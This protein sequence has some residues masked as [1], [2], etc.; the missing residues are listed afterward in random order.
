[1]SVEWYSSTTLLALRLGGMV[2]QGIDDRCGMMYACRMVEPS[3]V[4][5]ASTAGLARLMRLSLLKMES[6]KTAEAT[7]VAWALACAESLLDWMCFS[8]AI[9]R[10]G[11]AFGFLVDVSWCIVTPFIPL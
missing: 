7:P 11:K 5:V 3:G 1:M 10:F 2:L 6:R 9:G 4:M 8:P